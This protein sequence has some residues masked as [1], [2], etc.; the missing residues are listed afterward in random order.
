MKMVNMKTSKK[1]MKDTTVQA[2]PEMGDKDEYPYCLRIH[3]GD[4]ELKKL[5]FKPKDHKVGE[6]G[7]MQVKYKITSLETRE[8]DQGESNDACFQITDMGFDGGQK[9]EKMVLES[10]SR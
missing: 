3:L 1:E 7:T 8:T 4:D 10:K 6:T 9:E 2:M 5:K